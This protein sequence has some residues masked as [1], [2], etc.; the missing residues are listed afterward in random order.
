MARSPNSAALSRLFAHGHEFLR[1]GRM[2]TDGS[3][4]LRLGCPAFHRDRD[5]LNNFR[6]LRPNHM[7]ANHSFALWL[8]YQFHQRAFVTPAESVFQWPKSRFVDVHRPV[9]RAR[10]LFSETHRSD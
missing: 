8:H 6:R 2:N 3:I 10:F 5:A 9:A 7:H 1:G 4:E